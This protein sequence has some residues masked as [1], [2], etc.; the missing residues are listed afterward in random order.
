MTGYARVAVLGAGSWGTALAALLAR[1][2]VP[3]TLWGRDA[4]AMD[5]M[6]RTRRNRRYLPDS[7]LPAE[8]VYSADLRSSIAHRNP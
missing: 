2:G 7:E 6:A 5:E 8:L 1:H 3:T 4:T